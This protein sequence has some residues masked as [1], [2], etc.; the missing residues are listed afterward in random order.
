MLKKVLLLLVLCFALFGCKEPFWLNFYTDKL[1]SNYPDNLHNY[2]YGTVGTFYGINS[3]YVDGKEINYFTD[4]AVKGYIYIEW[5]IVLYE[6]DS[7]GSGKTSIIKT[8][9]KYSKKAY[10]D[11][12]SK[13][14]LG[15]GT[16]RVEGK[17]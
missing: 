17:E 8:V 12:D 14:Y 6:Y 5:K 10:I 15:I 11:S 1:G 4:E 13:I 9:G 2:G 7:N 3:L 16:V